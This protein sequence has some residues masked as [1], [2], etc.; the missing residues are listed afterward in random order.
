MLHTCMYVCTYAHVTLVGGFPIW[1]KT[2]IA[3]GVRFQTKS[4]RFLLRMFLLIMCLSY[5]YYFFQYIII[6]VL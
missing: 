6:A 2:T 5:L 1:A 3:T 4:I